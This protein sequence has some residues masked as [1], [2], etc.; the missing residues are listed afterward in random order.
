MS[1][2]KKENVNLRNLKQNGAVTFTID[3]LELQ[4]LLEDCKAKKIKVRVERYSSFIT[5]LR[6]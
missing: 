5:V 3:G 4:Q 2:S 1:K 6:E